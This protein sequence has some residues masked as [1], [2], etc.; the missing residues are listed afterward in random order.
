MIIAKKSCDYVKTNFLKSDIENLD[1]DNKKDG[2][3]SL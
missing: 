3:L 1:S 2:S